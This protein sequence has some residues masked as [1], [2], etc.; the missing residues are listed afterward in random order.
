[1]ERREM[2][3]D[4]ISAKADMSEGQIRAMGFDI[5]D[6]VLSF[7]EP[8]YDYDSHDFW[9]SYEDVSHGFIVAVRAYDRLQKEAIGNDH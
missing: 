5:W 1:M 3:M 7:W 8:G 2:I 6:G 9:D 4:A